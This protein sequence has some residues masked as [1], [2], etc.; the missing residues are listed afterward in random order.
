MSYIL[1][2][3]FKCLLY[4]NLPKVRIY[5]DNKFIDEFNIETSIQSNLN[6]LSLNS[7]EFYNFKNHRLSP[8]QS[9]EVFANS[10]KS[11]FNKSIFFRMYELDE[12]ILNNEQHKLVID[13]FNQDNNY[14]NGFLT[15]TTLV[16]LYI[17]YLVPKKILDKSNKFCKIYNFKKKK[18]RQS[19]SSIDEIK[20]DL[21]FRKTTMFNILENNYDRHCAGVLYV[22]KWY[23]KKNNKTE[24]I[25]PGQWVSE[26]KFKLFFSNE[27]IQHNINIKDKEVEKELLCRLSN[28]Y[29]EYEN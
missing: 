25:H 11:F 23:N 28:K 12:N 7:N 2:L 4:K 27:S 15:K 9:Y 19:N 14:T 10:S 26:G 8:K 18:Y 5:L 1:C 17:A 29:K 24:Q 3:G 22:L 20:K 6:D 13:I 16:G 21:V